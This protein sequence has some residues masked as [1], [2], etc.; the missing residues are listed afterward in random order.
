MSQPPERKL[1]KGMNVRYLP[2]DSHQ[3]WE[4]LRRILHKIDPSDFSTFTDMFAFLTNNKSLWVT[5][6]DIVVD[7]AEEQLQLKAERNPK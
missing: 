3:K 6:V 4:E 5:L 7:T 2:L 1:T